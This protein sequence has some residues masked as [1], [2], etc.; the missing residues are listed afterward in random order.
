MSVEDFYNMLKELKF[1]S[2]RGYEKSFQIQLQEM[3]EDNVLMMEFPGLKPLMKKVQFHIRTYGHTMRW[4]IFNF[5]DQSN[6]TSNLQ[7][8]L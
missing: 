1:M 6:I 5:F 3:A 7:K 4:I 8:L 2:K